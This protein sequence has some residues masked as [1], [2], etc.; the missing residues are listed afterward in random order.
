MNI[1]RYV[2]LLNA[3]W[4]VN[5]IAHLWGMRPYDKNISPAD[6]ILV[7]LIAMGEGNEIFSTL[8]KLN[9]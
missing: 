9:Y 3:T 8:V 7:G 4:S 1:A 2:S 6:S 5:S